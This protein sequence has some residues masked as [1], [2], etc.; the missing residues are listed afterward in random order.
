VRLASSLFTPVQLTDNENVVQDGQDA[1]VNVIMTAS[2]IFN[3][4]SLS[5][6]KEFWPPT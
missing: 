6:F 3:A 5:P 2:R 1:A 4:P